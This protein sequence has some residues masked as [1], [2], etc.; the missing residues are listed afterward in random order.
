MWTYRSNIPC[1]KESWTPMLDIALSLECLT[2]ILDPY[3][4][5]SLQY[6]MP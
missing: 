5:Y 3:H 2:I 1:G 4:I 6:N